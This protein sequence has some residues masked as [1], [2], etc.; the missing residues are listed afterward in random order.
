[1][2][3]AS[4]SDKMLR[5]TFASI[6]GVENQHAAVLYAVAALLEANMPQLIKLDGVNAMLPAAA[7]SVGFPDT[8]VK[9]D[10]ARPLTEGAVK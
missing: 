4:V 9:T 3:T 7:G 1:V 5:S 6:A 10:M 2:A 8:F